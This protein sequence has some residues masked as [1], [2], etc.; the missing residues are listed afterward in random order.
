LLQ[1]LM[2]V[3]LPIETDGGIAGSVR[4][5]IPVTEID[6]T[7]DSL[8]GKIAGTAVLIAVILAVLSL[9]IARRISRPLEQMRLG[10]EKFAQ[11]QLD[12]RLPTGGAE[13][14]S[15]LGT[16]LN[17]M[18]AQLD[19]RFQ[20]V[21]RQRNELEAVLKSMIEGVLAVD[22]NEQILRLNRAA[23][24]LFGT[25]LQKAIGRPVQEVLRKAE[26]QQFI[27]DSLKAQNPIERDLTLLA[28]G[29]EIQIQAHGSPLLNARNEKIGTLV[30][31]NDVTRLRRLEN[32]RRDFVA[33][34]SHELKTPITAIKG[35]AET[36]R[37]SCRIDSDELKRPIEVIVRQAD[38][39]NAIIND[40]LDLSRIEQQQDRAEIPR[41]TTAV[42]PVVEA[43]VQACSVEAGNKKISIV[44]DVPETLAAPINP[45]LL[46]QAL[47]NLLNN[48]VKYSPE[49]SRIEIEAA[50]VGS[51][52]RLAVR[53]FG[54]GIPAEH[55]PRLFERF[56]RVDTARS[57]EMGGTGL[58]LAI[59][60]HIAQAHNGR[61][62]VESTPGEGST[63]ILVLSMDVNR[64]S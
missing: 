27:D 57:R 8:H 10:A 26:L 47:V 28:A 18:A 21:I 54:C 56:Y 59:V 53:D 22:N 5:A 37:E 32:L 61:I 1:N 44:S 9:L 13:E 20:T 15:A 12:R 7:L 41:Q 63:F 62:E 42:R 46:E 64:R 25:D 35:W 58:G 49:N 31:V 60:K 4:T 19:E 23:A 50:T 39:L 30:V 17:N 6:A 3:A 51:E 43:S 52:L 45:P 36:L 29:R 2:Y 48:A 40:L 11:G 55:L 34:V 14:V 24:E 38:R 33:N 16:S